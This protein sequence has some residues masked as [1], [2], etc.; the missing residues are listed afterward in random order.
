MPD[1]QALTV[2]YR[3]MMES[4]P[5]AVILL[6]LDAGQLAHANGKAAAL[7]GM[8]VEALLGG[9]LSDLS[10]PQQPDGTCSHTLFAHQIGR[11]LA[12]AIVGFDATLRHASARPIACEVRMIRLAMAT[13]RLVHIR[14]VDITERNRAD[15]LRVGQGRMLEMVARGAPL[16]DTLDQL[17]R[18]IESQ[19]DGVLCSVLL[20]ADDGVTMRSASAPSLPAAYMAA[21]DGVAIGPG[22]GSC[23]TAMFRKQTVIVADIA[24]DPLWAPYKDLVAPYGLR[25]CWSTPIYLDRDQVLG[26]FAMYYREV[27][28]PTDDDMRL[29]AVATHLAGIAIERT[30][31]ERE[32]TL[33][34]AHLE[35]LVAVRTAELTAALDTLSLTQ[36]E[37]VRRDKLA[38]LGTLVAGVAHELNTPLGNSLMVASTMAEHAQAL[39]DDMAQGLR[40]SGLQRYLDQ[41][42]EANT[43]LMR[44]LQRA[45]ALVAS[46]KQLAVDHSLSQRRSFSL[47]A[48]MDDLATQLRINIGTRPL[49]LEIAIERALVMDSYPGAL[50]QACNHL[51]DNCLIHAFAPDASGTIAL[52]VRAGA[53]DLLA[54]AVGDTGSGMAPELAARVYDPFFTTRLGSGG[55]GLGLHVT[56]NIVTGILG[57]RIE[58][59]TETGHGS[60][61][62]LLLPAVAPGFT[63]PA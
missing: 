22:V 12:G 39:A 62:T 42:D 21:L 34:R 47:S 1:S 6:D 25:A 37:L 61:F 50:A 5:D 48:L 13:R 31:R 53:R 11:V 60:V 45:A 7:F 44:N 58:L 40:R 14:F 46:F 33:H 18:L 10:P 3:V 54:I 59:H 16:G 26:T 52:T 24:S 30:R 57:G 36:E 23:G 20:L 2:D 28:S 49:T 4:S 41:A 38:A 15:Q 17:M 9:S 8:P 43:I 19:S 29:I 35:D 32:L 55:S 51:F 56:H 27:R 63:L